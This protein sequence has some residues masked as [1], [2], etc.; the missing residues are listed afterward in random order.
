MTTFNLQWPQ[1]IWIVLMAMRLG[2]FSVMHGKPRTGKFSIWVLAFDISV[3]FPLLW[4]G[5]FFSPICHGH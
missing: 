2:V 4:W 1:I 5:G 3:M